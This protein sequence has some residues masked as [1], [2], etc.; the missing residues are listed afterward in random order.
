MLHTPVAHQRFA[1]RLFAGF[2]VWV[3]QFGQRRRIDED[4]VIN[5]VVMDYSVF[6]RFVRL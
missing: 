2:D 6:R 4:T 1:N 3:S 5:N